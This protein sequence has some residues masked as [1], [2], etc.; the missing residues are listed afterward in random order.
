MRVALFPELTKM[1]CTMFGAWGTA[2]A[3][4]ASKLVQL[5]ALDWTTDGPFQQWPLLVRPRIQW[6]AEVYCARIAL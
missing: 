3:A 1:S 4:S 6:W 5:R 2:T